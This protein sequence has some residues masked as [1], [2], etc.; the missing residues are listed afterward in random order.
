MLPQPVPLESQPS[1]DESN[2]DTNGVTIR[3]P[4]TSFAPCSPH[5]FVSVFFPPNIWANS[6]CSS[7]VLLYIFTCPHLH[8]IS[9]A[10][11]RLHLFSSCHLR[12]SSSAHLL[13]FAHLHL[14]FSSAHLLT[15]YNLHIF[16]SSHLNIFAHLLSL[17]SPLLHMLTSSHLLSIPLSISLY[18]SLSLF[19]SPSSSLSLSLSLSLSPTGHHDTATFPTKQG[20]SLLRQPFRTKW[21]SRV[22]NWIF[23]QGAYTKACVR[24]S[25]WR[26]WNRVRVQATVCKK[27][28]CVK[29]FGASV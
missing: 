21:P 1:E 12:I 17:S 13:T 9:S 25:F 24:K 19:L 14:I 4:S 2:I 11:S 10:S 22:K 18:L 15:S 26:V 20:S 6:S 5:W 8:L 29:R 16:T 3:T 23:T 7:G 27:Y 28:L